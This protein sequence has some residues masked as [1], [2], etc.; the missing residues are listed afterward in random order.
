M[1]QAAGAPIS[2][3]FHA[4]RAARRGRRSFATFYRWVDDA[5]RHRADGYRRLFSPLVGLPDVQRIARKR[6]RRSRRACDASAAAA[7]D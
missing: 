6:F 5:P 3:R 7:G 2:G 1:A 4:H